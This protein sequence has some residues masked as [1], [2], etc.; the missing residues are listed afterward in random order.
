MKDY[1]R[2]YNSYAL[3]RFDDILAVLVAIYYKYAKISKYQ[4]TKIPKYKNTKTQEYQNM[5]FKLLSMC[6]T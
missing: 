6:F 2:G 5:N 4:N 1:G 3:A